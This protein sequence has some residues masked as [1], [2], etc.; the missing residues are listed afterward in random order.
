MIKPTIFKSYYYWT[1][2]ECL[3]ELTP[4]ADD[5]TWTAFSV[6]L[7][8]TY[9][10]WHTGVAGDDAISLKLLQAIYRRYY[11]E[12]VFSTSSNEC[13]SEYFTKQDELII[14]L[15]NIYSFTRDRYL[16]LIKLYESEKSKLLDGVKTTTTGVGRFNDTPQNITDGDEF[17]NN[18]H[19]TNITKS[20]AEAVSDIDTK[21]NRLDEIQR[22][23]R[24]LYKD[25]VDEFED[26]FLER[27]NIQ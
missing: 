16:Q 10:T 26:L 9:S 27:G 12:F 1:L 8:D 25:W 22:K 3:S 4:Y 14:K 19:I 21:I 11:N 18:T 2:K 17:G 23:L 20:T 15:A 6:V 5:T 13:D 24:N 7:G